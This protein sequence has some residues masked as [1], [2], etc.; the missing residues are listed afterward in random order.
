MIA[1]SAVIRPVCT[2]TREGEGEGKTHERSA[3]CQRL[4]LS[5]L[6]TALTA[7]DSVYD[8]VRDNHTSLVLPLHRM[9][10]CQL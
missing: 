4:S 7:D 3:Y 5:N 6:I 9:I 2:V 8:T 1:Q 10:T